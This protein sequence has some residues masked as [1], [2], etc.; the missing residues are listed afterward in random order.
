MS[1]ADLGRVGAEAAR[2]A[3]ERSWASAADLTA[4]CYRLLLAQD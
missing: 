1:R 2:F 3:A 4:E